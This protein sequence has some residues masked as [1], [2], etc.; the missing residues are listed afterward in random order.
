MSL[1]WVIPP[2]PLSAMPKAMRFLAALFLFSVGA[3]AQAP[4]I[5][6]VL[7]GVDSSTNLAPGAAAAIYGSNFGAGPANGVKVTVG[8]KN[9]YVLAVTENQLN[10]QL[11]MDAATG[12]SNLIVTINGVAS[13]PFAVTLNDY[14]PAI[15]TTDGSTDGPGLIRAQNGD[16]FSVTAPA[17]PG[18]ILLIFVTGLGVTNP[19]TPTGP[20]AAANPTAVLPT[21]TV[22]GMEADVLAA[23]VY[24]GQTGLYQINFMVPEDIQGTVR[25]AIKIGGQTSNE[26][27]LPLFGVSSLVSNASF[28]SVGV[29]SPGS[30]AT[31]FAN[32]IGTTDQTLGFP[33]TAFQGISVLFDGVAAP[34]FH[35]IGSSGQIDLLLPSDL[36]TDGEVKVQVK[37]PSGD[38]PE[39]TLNMAPAT[40]GMYF[41]ADPNTNG[42][43][44]VLAQFNATLWLAMPASMAAALNLADCAAIQAD[45]LTLC[46][47]PAAPGDNLVL[48]TTGLGLAT[49]DGDP[50]GDPLPTG[51]NPPADGSVLYQ[52]VVTPTV[53]VGGLPA[54]VQFAGIS[55]G[56]AG[57]YQ[58][59]FQVP[60]G[61][62]GDDIPV[63]VSVGDSPA[64]VRTI[65]IHAAQ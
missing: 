5:A 15:Y 17:K 4:T 27:T 35:L 12:Q 37:T 57:L 13:A 61:I 48:Y 44:N 7:N 6:A 59:N 22:N 8:G 38:T 46:G 23:A 62:S 3:F 28:G 30:I 10:I 43:F 32:G 49:P 55:P 19:P 58:I 11:P 29:G 21:V 2:A 24:P 16:S 52:N 53:T 39:Y 14:A 36:P 31:V 18:D 60:E 56:F 34:L 51:E 26:V 42:R 9:A 54:M 65:A 64:D 40:P 25:V 50:N 20:A 47:K 45:P 33:A 63:S 41:L 1:K